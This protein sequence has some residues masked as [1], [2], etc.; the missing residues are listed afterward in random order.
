MR[1]RSTNRAGAFLFQIKGSES[2][3]TTSTLDKG[4]YFTM[5][6]MLTLYDSCLCCHKVS[7]VPQTESPSHTNWSSRGPRHT[8]IEEKPRHQRTL[9][10]YRSAL[11]FYL[12]QKMDV[13]RLSETQSDAHSLFT[14]Q[15][16]LAQFNFYILDSIH[17]PLLPIKK[18]SI[19]TVEKV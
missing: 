4:K 16:V 18:S 12:I 3:A 5:I 11:I 19:F 9:T 7:S 1:G 15:V 17:N 6:N 14:C 10:I 2:L 8:L 13:T